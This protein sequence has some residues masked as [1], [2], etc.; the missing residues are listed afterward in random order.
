MGGDW[1]EPPGER[2][3]ELTLIGLE[4][5]TRALKDAFDACLLSPD[6]LAA[7]MDESLELSDPFPSWTGSTPETAAGQY[8][9]P[10]PLPD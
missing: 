10:R 5:D 7:A 6:E 9:R 4:M 2:R 8:S 3:Q 1:R